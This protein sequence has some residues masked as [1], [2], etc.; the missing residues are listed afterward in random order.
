MKYNDTPSYQQ[1]HLQGVK[2]VSPFEVFRI[3][4]SENI[5]IVDVR[6]ENEVV[7]SSID[8]ERLLIHPLSGII[9]SM[10]ALPKNEPL[11]IVCEHGERSVKVVN[12]L[13]VQGFAEVYNL[14]GG[15]QAWR[16]LGLPIVGGY[17]QHSCSNCGCGCH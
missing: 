9:D 16:E 12:L 15:M 17:E 10:D 14:D 4:G 5:S 13:N 6:E 8:C 7:A 1:I 11:I 2:H 3:M